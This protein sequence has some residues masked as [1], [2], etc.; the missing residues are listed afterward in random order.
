MANFLSFDVK[1]NFCA[2]IVRSTNEHSVSDLNDCFNQVL[3]FLIY[4]TIYGTLLNV[5][6]CSINL[7]C[8]YM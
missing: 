4:Y 2:G 6:I 7:L 1:G 8:K 3:T 5:H